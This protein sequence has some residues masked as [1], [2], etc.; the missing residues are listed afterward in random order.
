MEDFGQYKEHI[1][2]EIRTLKS[3]FREFSHRTE[4]KINSISVN[5]AVLNTKLLLMS[6]ISSTIV[7]CVVAYIMDRVLK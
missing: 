5:L 3:D 7:G 6:A 4:E 1:M 2:S